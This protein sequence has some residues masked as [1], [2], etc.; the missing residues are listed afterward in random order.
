MIIGVPWETHDGERRVATTPAA[1]G[2][3]QK[4][5]FQVAIE[6]QAGMAAKFTDDAYQQ[7]GVSLVVRFGDHF[8]LAQ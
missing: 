2:L 1:V 8:F 5:G 4:L 7:A 3:I 6:T